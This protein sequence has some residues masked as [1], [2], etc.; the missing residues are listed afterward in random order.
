MLTDS[1]VDLTAPEFGTPLS[2]DDVVARNRGLLVLGSRLHALSDLVVASLHASEPAYRISVP[3]G[4]VAKSVSQVLDACRCPAEDRTN[5]IDWP[6]EAGRRRAQRGVPLDAVGRAYHI[7]GQVLVGSFME[8]ASE[9]QVPHDR[10]IALADDVW[11]VVDLHCSTATNAF[12]AAEDEMSGGRRAGKLLDALLNSES[13]RDCVVAVAQ[14]LGL[15]EQARY[16]VVVQRPAEWGAPPLEQAELP[17]RV[18]GVQVIWRVHRGYALGVAALGDMSATAFAQALPARPGRRTGVS[19]VVDNLA[20]LGRARRL[21][22]LAARTV[23]TPYGVVC[24]EERL[25]AALLTARSDLAG[26]LCTRVLAPV[27]ALDRVGRDLLLDTFAAW[28]E[29]GGSAHRA[30][31]TLFCHRN[32]VLNRLRQLERLTRRSVAVPKDLVE[33]T[34]ALEAFQLNMVRS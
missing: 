34:L 25:P 22:E 13:D 9:E 2:P 23:T 28:L 26:E 3:T 21:A 14:A 18:T 32:T 31:T 10:V 8:W 24:L 6:R 33:L 19:L 15:A 5:T 12:R 7:G 20:E 11:N 29:A 27:L 4:E 30:A 16:A 1:A 17:A